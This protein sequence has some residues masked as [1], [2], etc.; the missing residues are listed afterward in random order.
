MASWF[1]E[2]P[3]G[4]YII[5]A[6]IG[7]FFVVAFFT[8][9]RMV[10]LLYLPSIFGLMGL[11]CLIDVM[12]ITDREQVELAVLELARAAEKG[13]LATI[14]RL[15]SPQF[16]LEGLGRDSMLDRARKYLLPVE[17]RSI[18]FYNL[19]VPRSDHP[20]EFECLCNV[21][22][23]GQFNGLNINSTYIGSIDFVLVKEADDNWR[24]KSMVVKNFG[25]NPISLPR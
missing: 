3:T 4:A 12:V 21:S 24:I 2:H 14:E 13:D 9:R 1:T 8:T 15:L 20:R 16:T 25:G 11:V 7:L 19:N 5:L 23:Y 6:L 17:P 18:S 10:H 22:V